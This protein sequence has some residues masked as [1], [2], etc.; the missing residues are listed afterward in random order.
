MDATTSTD[1]REHIVGDDEDLPRIAMRYGVTVTRLKEMNG[2]IDG[3][4]RPGQKIKIP[5]D[6]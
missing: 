4:V 2:L 3:A 5:I 6:E 1:I